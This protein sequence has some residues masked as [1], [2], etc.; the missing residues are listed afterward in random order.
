MLGLDI[1]A[2]MKTVNLKVMMMNITECGLYVNVGWAGDTMNYSVNSPAGTTSL[3]LNNSDSDMN[4]DT[5]EN[6]AEVK[7]LNKT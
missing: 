4:S 6:D 3:S 2:D 7:D 5:E 1:R